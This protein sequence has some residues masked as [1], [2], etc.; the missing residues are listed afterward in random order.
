MPTRWIEAHGR[1]LPHQIVAGDELAEPGMERA[2]VIVLEIDLDERL[3]VVGAVVQ[4]DP[5][6]HVAGEVERLSGQ[7]AEVLR[8]VALPVE[9]QAVPALHRCAG[10]ARARLLGELRRAE[11]LTLE[12]VGPTVHRT[13]DVRR[14]AAAL[15]HHR[16]PVTADVGQELDS[17]GTADQRLRVVTPDE[18]VV[19]AGLR[20]HQLVPDVTRRARKQRAHLGLENGRVAVP[21]CGELK[22]GAR[23]L[24]LDGFGAFGRGEIRH[25]A[26]PFESCL[27]CP[28]LPAGDS[29][30][31]IAA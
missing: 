18:R 14:A 28:K 30:P 9:Q 10:E 15:Q 21:R 22:G 5:V 26:V 19:V 13:D 11:Q 12:V 29:R 23:R 7:P 24:P 3:P 8:D 16:L 27:T 31:A 1:E 6:E 2:D 20:H 4:L 25:D 17:V